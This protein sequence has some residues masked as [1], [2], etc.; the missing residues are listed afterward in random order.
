MDWADVQADMEI[1][2]T[3]RADEAQEGEEKRK[4]AF[5]TFTFWIRVAFG[6]VESD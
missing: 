2:Y 3:Y 6:T 4:E 1:R 5:K